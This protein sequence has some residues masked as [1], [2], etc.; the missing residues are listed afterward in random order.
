FEYSMRN[1][2]PYIYIISEIQDDPEN[3]MFWF[4][5]K[6]SSSDES[7]LELITKSERSFLLN[8]LPVFILLLSIPI[9]SVG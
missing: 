7:D 1:G 4:L 2:K 5:F 6:T 9:C 3:G 8:Y